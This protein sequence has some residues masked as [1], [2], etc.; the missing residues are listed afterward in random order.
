MAIQN[1][2][3]LTKNGGKSPM[4][5]IGTYKVGDVLNLSV[6]SDYSIISIQWMRV[7]NDVPTPI[8]NQT[9]VNY[10]ITWD[11][12][13]KVVYP[14]VSLSTELN[15]N[16]TVALPTGWVVLTGSITLPIDN[17]PSGYVYNGST[18]IYI[19]IPYNLYDKPLDFKVKQLGT[20]RVN[21]V[22]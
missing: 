16:K 7:I 10:T 5:L 2:I 21:I 13:G 17:I 14:M 19:K 12:Y 4:K 20:G 8:P 9:S 3:Q 6:I 1:S 11:D 18:D 15:K 22:T